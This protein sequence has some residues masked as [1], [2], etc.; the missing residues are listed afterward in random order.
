MARAGRFEFDFVDLAKA[1]QVAELIA[2]MKARGETLSVLDI[3]N[4]ADWTSLFRLAKPLQAFGA[5]AKP[6]STIVVTK[7][8]D[9]GAWSYGAFKLNENN[10]SALASLRFDASV[11]L[12]DG[13]A[14]MRLFSAK[15]S[16]LDCDGRACGDWLAQL[17]SVS[18]G[19]DA[20]LNS[21]H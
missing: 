7:N 18:R 2:S 19:W 17:M 6:T 3:S 8:D 14:F 20:Y 13:S 12:S 11:D 5:V 10:L 9:R 1:N 16:R 21:A 15:S 4:V